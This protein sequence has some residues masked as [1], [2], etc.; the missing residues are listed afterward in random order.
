M[1][2]TGCSPFIKNRMKKV[3]LLA[4]FGLSLLTVV[5]CGNKEIQQTKGVVS[6]IKVVEDSLATANIVV[7]GDTLLFK[8]AD[9][10]FVNGM[11]LKGDSV[12]ID[13]IE[14]RGDTLRALV[15]AVLPKPVHYIDLNNQADQSDTLATRQ[16]QPVDSLE[17]PQ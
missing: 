4:V 6:S 14:G 3:F 15:I 1:P 17:I 10:R 7:D 5:S 8:L 11:F 16:S 9:A 12:T 2:I 13:Y